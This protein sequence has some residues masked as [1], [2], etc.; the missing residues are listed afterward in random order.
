[1]E[2][3]FIYLLKSA[4][5]LSIF[6]LTYHFLLRRL[7]FFR[8]N[9]YFLL[10]GMIASIGFPLI[11]ITQV[12]YVEQPV[13]TAT[14]Q[15]L[16][17][18]MAYV[19]QEPVKQPVL[20]IDQ[21]LLYLY[22][23]ISLFFL[24]KMTVELLSLSRLIRAGKRRI[25]DGFVRISL[26]RKVTPFSFFNYICFYEKEENS[27]ASD[28]I[29]KHE[30]VHAREWHSIDLLLTHLYCAIFWMNPLAWWLKRQ[31]GENLE[32]IADAHAKVENTTG[33]SYER[34]LLSS[35]ASHMQPALANNFFTPFIKKRIQMLQ[36]ETSKTWNAYKYALILPV[37][38]LFL[39]S[40]NTVTKTEYVKTAMKKSMVNQEA[41][42]SENMAAVKP[43]Q[44]ETQI[45]SLGDSI[46]NKGEVTEEKIEFKI[47]PTT[48][49]ESLE[50]IKKQLKSDHNVDL[51]IS[52]LKYKDGK[53]TSINIQLDD[54][55]G[56]KGS[57]SYTDDTAIPTICITG[58]IDEKRKSWNMGNCDSPNMTVI[59]S[60]DQWAD[61]KAMIPNLNLTKLELKMD[62]E[63]MDSLRATLKRMKIELA[64]LDIPEMDAQMMKQLKEMQREF[65][66]MN[67]DSMQ[68]EMKKSIR[69]ARQELK[70]TDMDSIRNQMKVMRDSLRKNVFI[71]REDREQWRD[72]MLKN[73]RNTI[74]AYQGKTP[75][76]GYEGF[77]SSNSISTSPL[78][79]LDGQAVQESVF[80]NLNPNRIESVSV[81]KDKSATSIYGK[82]G[83]NGVII[84]TTKLSSSQ[85]KDSSAGIQYSAKSAKFNPDDKSLT[86]YTPIEIKGL[87]G[88]TSDKYPSITVDGKKITEEEFRDIDPQTIKLINVL[89]GEAA[90]KAYGSK[91][92][93]GLIEIVLKSAEEMKMT[94]DEL[95]NKM[96]PKRQTTISSS[97]TKKVSF[98]ITIDEFTDSEMSLLEK[99]L[100]KEGYNFNLKTFR[101]KGNEVSKLKFD[102]DGTSY[103]FE[104]RN[105]IKSLTISINNR[106]KEPQ[107]S[108]VTF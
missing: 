25:E 34:T 4:G 44:D 49:Q 32:F 27:L 33:I 92:E 82:E 70:K 97:P 9:R 84:V 108:A 88:L 94:E 45:S 52:N 65:K 68:R 76:E 7:T 36:K 60:S 86:I 69:V 8:A 83:E 93:N 80:K 107:V 13:V 30:Q 85:K 61:L 40:F 64:N 47:P 90:T 35:A 1:M 67:M 71:L 43:L 102:L 5:V 106:D 74:Y 73:Q 18:P 28:L 31:I 17:T 53:I 75:R 101:K 77:L 26:S 91:V 24:G 56:F 63:Q 20:D 62:D 89:K 78:F 3:A 37:I 16:M 46:E 100:K 42:N 50:R 19:L 12:V 11:E 104:P 103:T 105:G 41:S 48:T 29:L 51:K 66:N 22:A 21:M 72:S 81:L 14:P 6:V 96:F 39:Y 54:N 55:R 2:E 10:F 38:V 79:I 58:I 57:Q 95:H 23:A 99:K 98:V 15:P 87:R 59:Q